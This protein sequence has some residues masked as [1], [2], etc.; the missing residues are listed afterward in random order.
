MAP[1]AWIRRRERSA[2]ALDCRQRDR[3][4]PPVR[5]T[6]VRLRPTSMVCWG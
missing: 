4:E 1:L 3:L 6:E 5:R 2:G